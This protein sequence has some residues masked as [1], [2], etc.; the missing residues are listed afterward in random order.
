MRILRGLALTAA[1]LLGAPMTVATAAPGDPCPD[2]ST[3]RV[4]AGPGLAS[5]TVPAPEGQLIDQ[6]CVLTVAGA[7]PVLVSLEPLVPA[8]TVETPDGA[9]IAEYSVSFVLA[10]PEAEEPA[11]VPAEEVAVVAPPQAG[12]VEAPAAAR[13]PHAVT[14]GSGG[15]DGTG[16]MP[17]AV[18]LVLGSLLAVAAGVRLLRT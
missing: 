15:T 18:L 2:L 8:V 4:V 10:P 17:A 16:R 12:T 1:L 13:P 3:G 9:D 7:E 5:V 11:A 14:A 6:Y